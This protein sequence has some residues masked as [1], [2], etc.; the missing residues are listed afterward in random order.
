[1]SPRR[2][3]LNSIRSTTFALAWGLTASAAFAQY[4]GQIKKESKDA[5]T[6]RAIAVLEWTGDLGKPKKSRLI[7]ITVY[8]GQDLHDGNIY[9]ARPHPLALT[10]D[11]EYELLKNGAPVG[12]YDVKKA[13]QEQGMWVGYGSWKPLPSAKPSKPKPVV[14]TGFDADDDRPVLH[15]KSSESGKNSDSTSSAPAPDPDRPTLHKPADETSKESSPAPDPDRPTNHKDKSADPDRP[16]LHKPADPDT[17]D[18]EHSSF[19]DPD[20]PRLLRGKPTGGGTDVLPTLLGFPPDMQQ[21]VAVSDAKSRPEHTWGYTWA[22]PADEDKMKA[23]M[24][25]VA[26]TALGLKTPPPPPL[27]NTPPPTNTRSPCLL[28][29]LRRFRTSNSASLNS[30]TA[31]A[32]P[33]SSQLISMDPR[34]NRSSSPSSLSPTSTAAL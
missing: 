27:P 17:A 33:W 20:R 12:L 29:S 11:V 24:E 21:A 5:P 2:F 26:R 14:D 3:N 18:G 15:R 31:Q 22:N 9:L 34:K 7:P 28:R 25:D 8:D 23:A 1:M 30:P 32:Q 10:G 4:P 16:V 13:G 19:T 6:L